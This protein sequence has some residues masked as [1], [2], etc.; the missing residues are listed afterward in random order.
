MKLTKEALEF[1]NENGYYPWQSGKVI[2]RPR[3]GR[4]EILIGKSAIFEVQN[5]FAPATLVTIE[6]LDVS[7]DDP[8]IYKV[9]YNN[10]VSYV[11]EK[12][13]LTGYKY[14]GETF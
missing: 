11:K 12:T 4:F 14:I 13:L 2:A 3:S 5:M 8:T 6:F 10:S 9:R 1:Y 7:P